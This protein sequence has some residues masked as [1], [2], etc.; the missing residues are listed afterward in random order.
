MSLSYFILRLIPRIQTIPIILSRQFL[1]R[2]LF[3]VTSNW[4]L[5]CTAPDRRPNG[6]NTGAV[7]SRLMRTQELRERACP[8]Y[9]AWVGGVVWALD[10]GASRALVRSCCRIYAWT[11]R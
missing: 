1:F 3:S 9:P 4:A 6:G 11:S 2:A 5:G 10:D 7:H 8:G